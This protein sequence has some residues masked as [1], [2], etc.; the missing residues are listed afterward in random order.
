MTSAETIKHH[1]MRLKGFQENTQWE[2]FAHLSPFSVRANDPRGIDVSFI[3][4]G[5][6]R[7]Y[8][9]PTIFLKISCDGDFV[10]P[11]IVGMDF[12]LSC[13]LPCLHKLG[14]ELYS[15]L[16][17]HPTSGEYAVERLIDSLYEDQAGVLS[18]FMVECA[19]SSSFIT[20]LMFGPAAGLSKPV[21]AHKKFIGEA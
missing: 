2:S 16:L 12:H 18:Y 3:G 19:V 6:L 10:L 5:F 9:S 15:L 13:L 7:R 4:T 20:M 21:S 1:R 17:M 11:I 8:Q 14:T